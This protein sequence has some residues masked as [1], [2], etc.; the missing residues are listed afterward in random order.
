MISHD[1][2]LNSPDH[3]IVVGHPFHSM[4]F[5]Q[6]PT[7]RT[8]SAQTE[9]TYRDLVKEKKFEAV[10]SSRLANF[11]IPRLYRAPFS[12]PVRSGHV[13]F[14]MKLKQMWRLTDRELAVMLGLDPDDER[15]ISRLLQGSSD[16]ESRDL[17]DRLA[18]LLQIRM[19]LDNL[20]QDLD[21]ENEWLREPHTMLDSR[22]PMSLL[23][24]GPMRDLIVVAQYVEMACGL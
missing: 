12:S 21:Q 2:Q 22:T 23:L 11:V 16:L 6:L 8:L 13:Q 18:Y 3:W 1:F 19:L 17:K 4:N 14:L 9:Y 10:A 20:L 15:Q 7:T 24:E 5:P